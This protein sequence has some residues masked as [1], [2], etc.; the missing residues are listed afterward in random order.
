MVKT[1]TE[2]INDVYN[3]CYKV[4]VENMKVEEVTTS[5]IKLSW[6]KIPGISQYEVYCSTDENNNYKK[7]ETVTDTTYTQSGLKSGQTYYYKIKAV[8]GEI[9]GS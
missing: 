5:S 7:I 8:G 9:V 6:D 2:M 4:Q 1:L 3:E